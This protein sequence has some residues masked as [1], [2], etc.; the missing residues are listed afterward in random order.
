MNTLFAFDYASLFAPILEPFRS[1][2][3]GPKLAVLLLAV[4]AVVLVSFLASAMLQVLRLMAALRVIVGK[5]AGGG[6][7]EK[8]EI[9]QRDFDKIDRA[10]VSNRAVSGPWQ[11][12]RKN[13]IVR[14]G[15][16]SQLI[17]SSIPARALFNAR[18]TRVQYD[19]VRSLPNLFVG[20]GLLGTFIGLI[21]ALTFST[22]SLTRAADQEQIKNAL[23]LLLTTAAA[24]FYISAAGLLSSLLLSLFVRGALKYIHLLV[25]AI[26]HALEERILYL[27][28]EA[29]SEQQFSV[30]QQSLEELKLF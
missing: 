24:K 9:F 18:S 10:L 14:E 30:Q 17:Y 4:A 16:H 3:F 6:N 13:F 23:S 5:T 1:E 21:A 26:N 12:F 2:I 28:Q 7:Q 11:E 27:S 8:R 29:I 15:A 19:F 25:H 20:L 22:E